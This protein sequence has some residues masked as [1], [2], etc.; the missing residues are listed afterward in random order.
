MHHTHKL[1]QA[2]WVATMGAILYTLMLLAQYPQNPLPLFSFAALFIV[3][4]G[5]C[6]GATHGVMETLAR[7]RRNASEAD[8]MNRILA[9]AISGCGEPE[10]LLAICT[11]LSDFLDVPQA[12]LAT[13]DDTRTSMTIVAER[14]ARGRKSFLGSTMPVSSDPSVQRLVELKTPVAVAN[15][16]THP[17][18]APLVE[19]MGSA[20]HP[21]GT[22]SAL[23][24]PIHIQKHVMGVLA[25]ETFERREFTAQEIVLTQAASHQAGLVLEAMRRSD[26]MLAHVLDLETRIAEYRDAVVKANARLEEL[27]R[28]D[29]QIASGISDE[30]YLTATYPL[31]RVDVLVTNKL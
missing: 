12:A 8:L 18:T 6:Y 27:N 24:I 30:L 31:Q 26:Q 11:E 29:A 28:F 20:I 25:L 23:I 4:V 13:L 1:Y 5:L 21:R 19:R 3:A 15:V 14:L 17:L 22:V 10:A 2:V 9:V 7:A 16:C